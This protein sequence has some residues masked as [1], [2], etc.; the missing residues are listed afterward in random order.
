MAAKVLVVKYAYEDAGVCRSYYN[1]VSLD[2]VTYDREIFICNQYEG[3][4]ISIWYGCT[5]S[6]DYREPDSPI[7]AAIQIV[8]RSG[9]VLREPL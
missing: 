3:G 2:G 6:T 9:N 8:E 7:R 4:G 1:V 5:S